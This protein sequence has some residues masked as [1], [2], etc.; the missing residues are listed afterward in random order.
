M[1]RLSEDFKKG[2]IVK[3]GQDFRYSVPYKNGDL[4]KVMEVA[5]WDYSEIRIELVPLIMTPEYEK[6]MSRRLFDNKGKNWFRT[7]ASHWSSL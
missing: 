1:E 2:Q 3:A 6:W 5:K 7:C 4:F